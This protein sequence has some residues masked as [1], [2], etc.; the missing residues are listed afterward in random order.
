MPI[1][2]LERVRRFRARKKTG[3]AVLS[4]VIITDEIATADMLIAADLLEPNRADDPA[5][6]AAAVGK[7]IDGHVDRY[8]LEQLT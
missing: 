7:M 4:F 6:I 1:A 3:A 2:R 8:K 5:A